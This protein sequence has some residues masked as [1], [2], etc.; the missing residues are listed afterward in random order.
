MFDT[1]NCIKSRLIS[2]LFE[3]EI[4]NLNYYMKSRSILSFFEIEINNLSNCLKSRSIFS[5]FENEKFDNLLN[6][7]E[8]KKIKTKKKLKKSQNKKRI[9]IKVEKK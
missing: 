2:L 9:I 3:I 4:N 5:F 1:N 8:F 6:I 7:N